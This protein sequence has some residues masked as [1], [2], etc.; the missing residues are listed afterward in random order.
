[1]LQSD[2]KTFSTA[3]DK[4]KSEYKEEDL[5]KQMAEMIIQSTSYL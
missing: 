2:S 3:K 5:V 4:R 1:M